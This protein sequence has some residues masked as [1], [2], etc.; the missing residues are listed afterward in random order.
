M[1]CANLPRTLLAVGFVFAAVP[2]GAA[3][4][5]AQTSSGSDEIGRI[6]ACESNANGKGIEQDVFGRFPPQCMTEVVS[7]T[8]S[9]Q[10]RFDECRS[11]A[12]ARENDGELY[13]RFLHMC[14]AAPVGG[15]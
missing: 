11:Q 5:L 14:M 10:D 2:L 15:S 4:S 13:A 8:A 7:P 1:A 3:A 9:A 6:S 12:R